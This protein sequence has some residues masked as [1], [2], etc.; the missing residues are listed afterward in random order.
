[1][2]GKRYQQR[3]KNAEL[4]LLR[5]KM[6]ER[7]LTYRDLAAMAGKK[8]QRVANVLSGSDRTW[9]IRAAINRALRSKL[10]SKPKNTRRQRKQA[11]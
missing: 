11:P 7:G 2:T 8:P 4:D 5:I 10:F 6:I 1:M 9:P 3:G